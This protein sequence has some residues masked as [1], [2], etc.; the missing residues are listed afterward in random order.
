MVRIPTSRAKTWVSNQGKKTKIYGEK[1]KKREKK[2]NVFFSNTVIKKTKNNIYSNGKLGLPELQVTP[3]R[4]NTVVTVLDDL[5]DLGK[6]LRSSTDGH[7]YTYQ[8]SRESRWLCPRVRPGISKY[9]TYE[10][11]RKRQ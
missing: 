8:S 9:N 6:P 7:L 5:L 11:G 3:T 10:G 1:E 2:R 4:K